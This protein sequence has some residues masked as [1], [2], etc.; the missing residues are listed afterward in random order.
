MT[1]PEITSNGR[2]RERDGFVGTEM[3][4]AF[5]QEETELA[6]K[7]KY[8]LS[9]EVLF[10]DIPVSS[11][12]SS[13]PEGWIS[14]DVFMQP[15][16]LPT[17]DEAVVAKAVRCHAP[18]VL[19]ISEDGKSVRRTLPLPDFAKQNARTVYIELPSGS[20]VKALRDELEVIGSPH[21]IIVPE[22]NP[23]TERPQFVFA[24][25]HDEDSAQHAIERLS[26]SYQPVTKNMDIQAFVRESLAHA[27]ENMR[28]KP[29]WRA[30]LK[31]QWDV[32]TNEYVLLHQERQ[33]Q[34]KQA[35]AARC[36]H[37]KAEFQSK[38]V[39]KFSH[40]HRATDAKTLKKLFSMVAPVT[41]VD[42]SPGSTTG[43]ARF[44]TPHGAKLAATYFTREYI[45]QNHKKDIG[46][47]LHRKSRPNKSTTMHNDNLVE[48]RLEAE[49]HE[50]SAWAE[51]LNDK[52]S[53][54]ESAEADDSAAEEALPS[55]SVQVLTAEDEEAYWE[56][57]FA[58]Q[59]LK[60]G[61]R[62]EA[63]RTR[64]Q[65]SSDV[66]PQEESTIGVTLAAAPA[67]HGK[68]IK[69]GSE[70]DTDEEAESPTATQNKRGVDLADSEKQV[71]PKRRKLS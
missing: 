40:V 49:D 17:D 51:G 24:V 5:A 22:F 70:S 7:L 54:A 43:Y 14:L 21:D 69:F 31:T 4:P 6:N 46:T 2:A 45:V 10:Y 33:R 36:G 18:Q 38:V 9:D 3:L 19:E 35:L 61:L 65:S 1:P 11:K 25:Y 37:N 47:L 34:L 28:K 16:K 27:K 29:M 67:P 30:I 62:S 57:I 53:D 20:G 58:Q 60:A 56:R 39:V 66:N 63:T 13:D 59:L 12:I 23:P 41:F 32:L 68:H 44:K 64:H 26:T 71:E 8:Y 48:E 15:G 42:H 55:I 52:P 50:S